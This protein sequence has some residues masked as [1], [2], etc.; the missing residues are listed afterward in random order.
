MTVHPEDPRVVLACDTSTRVGSVALVESGV[1]T[2]ESLFHLSAH[3]PTHFGRQGTTR[4]HHSRRVLEEVARLLD[5]RGLSVRD[6]GLFV[7]S[8]GPGSFTGVRTTIATLKGLAWAVGRPLAGVC[9]LRALAWPLFGRGAPVLAALDAR[10]GEVYAALYG[11]DGSSLLE[12]RAGSAEAVAEAASPLC[13][14]EVLGVGEGVLAVR[15]RIDAAL[16][17]RLVLAEGPFHAIRA[18]VLAHLG[19]TSEPIPVD[20]VE[21][22]YLRRPEAEVRLHRAG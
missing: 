15:E 1:V 6:V 16:G 4:D 19:M 11:P 13:R 5:W 3:P 7:A 22:L 21:P 20:R 9:S 2:G 12:P 17:G 18:S 10:K 8:L 14:G